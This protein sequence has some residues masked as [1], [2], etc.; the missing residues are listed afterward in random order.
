MYL[1]ALSV[2]SGNLIVLLN[3]KIHNLIVTLS[4]FKHIVLRYTPIPLQRVFYSVNHKK[5]KTILDKDKLLDNFKAVFIRALKTLGNPW[6]SSSD[7]NKRLTCKEALSIHP[8]LLF[9]SISC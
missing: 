2:S 1:R 5:K 3:G 8:D 7:G 4:Y 9:L 6:I